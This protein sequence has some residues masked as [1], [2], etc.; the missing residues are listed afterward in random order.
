MIMVVT[1]SDF[2]VIIWYHEQYWYHEWFLR[3]KSERYC[4]QSMAFL[5]PGVNWVSEAFMFPVSIT[6]LSGVLSVSETW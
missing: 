2:L 6:V 5:S 3:H 1:F 4:N